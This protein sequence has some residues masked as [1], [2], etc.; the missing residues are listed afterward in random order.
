MLR[1]LSFTLLLFVTS[2]LLHVQAQT[3]C[4]S[5]PLQPG[6]TLL[7]SFTCSL[8]LNE[9]GGEWKGD[10]YLTGESCI[11]QF[12]VCVWNV[13][14]TA[15]DYVI[16]PHTI[17][18][19][20]SCGAIVDATSSV[21]LFD[22][23]ARAAVEEGSALGFGNCGG[24]CSDITRVFQASCVQRSNSGAAT[25]FLAC[26]EQAFCIRAFTVCCPNNAGQPTVTP[27]PS[28]TTTTCSA[29]GTILS[30]CETTCP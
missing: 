20:S 28:T 18:F 13:G 27:I 17:R 3:I 21:T 10:L 1:T 6:A 8:N 19:G 9:V 14:G 16:I 2:T 29:S 25:S 22:W 23:F 11:T 5:H 7:G 15:V 30:G 4:S 12:E 26:D 24:P